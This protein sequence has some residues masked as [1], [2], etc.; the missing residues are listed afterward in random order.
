MHTCSR[1]YAEVC[2]VRD[3]CPNVKRNLV[4]LQ[5]LSDI[6]TDTVMIFSF[7]EINIRCN[8]QVKK[9]KLKN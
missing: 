3:G 2:T 4:G 6:F 7:S 1:N 8:C 9:P 5:A